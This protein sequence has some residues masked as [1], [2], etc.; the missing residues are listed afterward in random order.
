MT[1]TTSTAN[2]TSHQHPPPTTNISKP[3]PTREESIAPKSHLW[4]IHNNSSDSSNFLRGSPTKTSSNRS[5]E[6]VIDSKVDDD[7][8]HPQST[9]APDPTS[10]EWLDFST[11]FDEFYKEFA[12]FQAEYGN[13][14]DIQANEAST[15]HACCVDD[16]DDRTANDRASASFLQVIAELEQVNTQL[17]QILTKLENPAPCTHPSSAIIINPQQPASCPEPQPAKML[18]CISHGALDVPPAPNPEQSTAVPSAVLW[19]PPT[20]NAIMEDDDRTYVQRPPPAPDPDVD[21]V[22]TPPAPDPVDMVY[23][24]TLCPQPRP[25]WK[26]IPVKKKTKTKHTVVRRRDQDF[27]PP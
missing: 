5:T 4:G 13:P 21:M 11:E 17:F 23:K 27:R 22:P 6:A 26:P 8:S 20:T 2:H 14:N 9:T 18:Q 10:S 3:P 12:K 1:M 15:L 19:P 7:D 24:G 25:A 16:D